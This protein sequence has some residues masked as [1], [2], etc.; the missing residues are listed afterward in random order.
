MSEDADITNFDSKKY[1]K[2]LDNYRYDLTAGQQHS[3][4]QTFN[5]SINLQLEP[6]LIDRFA[7]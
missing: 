7:G 6:L 1:L 2:A 4:W 5:V 3:F